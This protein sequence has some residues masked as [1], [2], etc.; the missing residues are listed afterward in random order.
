MSKWGGWPPSGFGGR[1][2]GLRETAG[3]TQQQL[4]ERA[5]CNPFTVAKLEAG[6]QEPAW[7]LVRALARAL[8]VTCAAFD[9]PDGEPVPEPR[10]GRRRRP[11]K[12]GAAG[13]VEVGEPPRR[14][15]GRPGRSRR[16]RGEDEGRLLTSGEGL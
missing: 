4:G 5:G 7:P 13:Q 1:L 14:S 2:K 11:R 16:G 12:A 15:T 9:V 10:P 3:L 6:K 8:G